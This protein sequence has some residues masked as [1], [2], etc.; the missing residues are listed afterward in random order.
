MKIKTLVLVALTAAALTAC[1]KSPEQ[2]QKEAEETQIRH[3]TL[4]KT[5]AEKQGVQEYRDALKRPGILQNTVMTPEDFK[6]IR[7]EQKKLLKGS[8]T[9]HTAP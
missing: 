3:D 1:Q 4:E 8:E 9:P 6:R 2:I 5:A 7:E